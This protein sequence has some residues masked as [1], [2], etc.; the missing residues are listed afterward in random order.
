MTKELK[1][2]LLEP[3]HS[4]ENIKVFKNDPTKNIVLTRSLHFSS[5]FD[6]GFTNRVIFFT[7][8]HLLR[9]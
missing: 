1:A 2:L 9:R 8:K 4:I 6:N 7:F 3:F 5:K